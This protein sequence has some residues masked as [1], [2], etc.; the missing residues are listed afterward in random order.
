M[1]SSTIKLR[2][3][4]ILYLMLLSACVP[5]HQ[6][7]YPAGRGYSS[8]YG[9]TL[10][11]YYG[12]YPYNNYHNDRHH[13]DRRNGYNSHSSWYNGYV[14][15][16]FPNGNTYY[17]PHRHHQQFGYQDSV[18]AY[19]NYKGHH[20]LNGNHNWINPKSDRPREHNNPDHNRPNW[21]GQNYG[22]SHRPDERRNQINEQRHFEHQSIN[23]GRFENHEQIWDQRDKQRRDHYH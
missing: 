6:A 18:P 23:R 21:N 12:N 9:V 20:P 5:Y 3:F 19:P 13:L 10:G 14:R 8:S 7:Y 2:A 15:P 16:N 11:R 17:Y 1:N 4:G 22:Q